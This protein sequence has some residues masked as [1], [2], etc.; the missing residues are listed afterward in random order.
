MQGNLLFKKTH[1]RKNMFLETIQKPISC[2]NYLEHVK[3]KLDD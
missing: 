3:W 2:C 1:Q